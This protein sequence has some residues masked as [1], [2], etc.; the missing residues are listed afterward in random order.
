MS[1]C[2][3]SYI[4]GLRPQSHFDYPNSNVYP[5]GKTTGEASE[6]SIMMP[7]VS[8]ALQKA[9]IRNALSKKPG[10]NILINYVETKDITTLPLLFVTIYT[11]TVRVEGTAAKMD[12]GTQGLK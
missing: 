4:M 9:A 1:A 10:A 7:M 11:L 6:T 5:M 3:Q 12:I 8:S 2:T